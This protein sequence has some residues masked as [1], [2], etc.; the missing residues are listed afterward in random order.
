MAALFCHS[1]GAVMSRSALLLTLVLAALAG[2]A[3]SPETNTQQAA[4]PK[5]RCDRETP[6]GSAVAKKDC[7]AQLS[8]EDK[9]RL[10][11]ELRNRT[12]PSGVTAPGGGK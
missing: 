6:I 4:A 10:A 11:A 7:N 5:V 2:C 1:N 3:S 12:T 9:Q 8:E